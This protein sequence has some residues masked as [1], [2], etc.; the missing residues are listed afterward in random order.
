MTCF[1]LLSELDIA[2]AHFWDGPLLV[3]AVL[4]FALITALMVLSLTIVCAAGPYGFGGSKRHWPAPCLRG[5]AAPAV[6]A[7]ECRVS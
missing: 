7:G 3:R 4:Q 5:F 2:Q 1:A 6:L